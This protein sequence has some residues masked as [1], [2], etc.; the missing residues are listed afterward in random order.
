MTKY[1]KRINIFAKKKKKKKSRLYIFEKLPWIT[2]RV[3]EAISED[4]VA[5]KPLENH[6]Y[7]LQFYIEK[8]NK[9]CPLFLHHLHINKHRERERERE[10]E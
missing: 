8:Q 4:D 2:I 7:M 9:S 1:H 6:F 5:T 3:K 10:R